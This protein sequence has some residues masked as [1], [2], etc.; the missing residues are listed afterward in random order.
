MVLGFDGAG[1]SEGGQQV[2]LKNTCHKA[3]E[4]AP[5]PM[6]PQVLTMRSMIKI[7]QLSIPYRNEFLAKTLRSR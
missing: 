1:E 5:L 3:S 4:R 6:T 2:G 7:F